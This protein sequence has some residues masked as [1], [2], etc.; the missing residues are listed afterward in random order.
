MLHFAPNHTGCQPSERNPNDALSKV[1]SR[2]L[3][4]PPPQSLD[5]PCLPALWNGTLRERIGSACAS[6]LQQGQQRG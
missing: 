3:P 6:Q 1:V 4:F 5:V 2:P